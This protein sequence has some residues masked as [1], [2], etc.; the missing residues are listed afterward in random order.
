MKYHIHAL[1]SGTTFTFTSS[2]GQLLIRS[3]H[4]G[5]CSFHSCQF[6]YSRIQLLLESYLPNSP[7]LISFTSQCRCNSTHEGTMHQKKYRNEL[8]NCGYQFHSKG[9]LSKF[10]NHARGFQSTNYFVQRAKNI[11]PNWYQHK[12][13]I[14]PISIVCVLINL[15]AGES[16]NHLQIMCLL[17]TWGRK[18]KTKATKTWMQLLTSTEAL[19][20][21]KPLANMLE[22]HKF[23]QISLS[24][25]IWLQMINHKLELHCHHHHQL[26]LSWTVDLNRF[27]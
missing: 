12:I 11:V 14:M 7:I 8:V 16:F 22:Q 3:A 6:F 27:A 13:M 18:Q 10:V 21:W 2:L 15:V 4:W 19:V 24:K 9:L 25:F 5:S 26:H 1:L 17:A 20:L 23:R